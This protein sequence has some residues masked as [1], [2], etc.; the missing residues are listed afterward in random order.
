MHSLFH[1]IGAC[2]QKQ[3]PQLT[4]V[5]QRALSHIQYLSHSFPLQ[6]LALWLLPHP[7][8]VTNP[9]WI[10]TLLS[11]W[12]LFHPNLRFDFSSPDIV[13]FVLQFL[14]PPPPLRIWIWLYTCSPVSSGPFALWVTTLSLPPSRKDTCYFSVVQLRSL[15]SQGSSFLLH[16]RKWLLLAPLLSPRRRRSGI[17]GG[18]R[19]FVKLKKQML[20]GWLS[21]EHFVCLTYSLWCVRALGS[22]ITWFTM[23][24][25]NWW[26]LANL[27]MQRER[28]LFLPTK[29]LIIS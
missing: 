27:R 5:F 26:W 6:F 4:A 21:M 29:P 8:H 2:S 14:P 23:S 17:E 24:Q 15:A 28:Q 9:L 18:G 20:A 3:T 10:G 1:F 19:P 16:S 22:H 7:P 13:L 11:Y 12:H 25:L